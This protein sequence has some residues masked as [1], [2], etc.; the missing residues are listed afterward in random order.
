MNLHDI[1]R[2]DSPLVID[3][4][5]AGTYV[6]DGTRR[7]ADAGGARPLPDTDWHVEKLYAFARAEAARRS[8]WR[9]IRATSST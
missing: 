6:P 7:A 5:H 1:A 8:S 3:V 4:P 2:G 9:R